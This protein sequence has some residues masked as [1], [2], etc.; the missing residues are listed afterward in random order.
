[1]SLTSIGAPDLPTRPESACLPRFAAAISSA[2]DADG[3]NADGGGAPPEAGADAAAE[4]TP[5][6]AAA[7]GGGADAADAAAGALDDDAAAGAGAGAGGRAHGFSSG[8]SSD[9]I[10]QWLARRQDGKERAWLCAH[11]MHKSAT[12]RRAARGGTPLAALAPGPDLHRVTQ[13]TQGFGAAAPAAAAVFTRR[14]TVFVYIQQRTSDTEEGLPA[15]QLRARGLCV[16]SCR[17]PVR[18]EGG[19]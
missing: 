14:T 1:M 7:R 12:N 16:V 18:A 13:A 8:I 9:M 6:P 15:N 5:P 17:C 3:C 2:C 10:K 4:E 19:V 11:E